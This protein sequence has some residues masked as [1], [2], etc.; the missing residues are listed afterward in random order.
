MTMTETATGRRVD[1][2]NLLRAGELQ[3]RS[4]RGMDDQEIATIDDLY[5]D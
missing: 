1:T 4:V 5:I 2:W 3:G